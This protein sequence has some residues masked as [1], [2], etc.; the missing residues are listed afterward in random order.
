HRNLQDEVTKE[1]N[2]RTA[3]LH[4]EK[5]ALLLNSKNRPALSSLV[6]E[7]QN[8]GPSNDNDLGNSKKL[9][10]ISRE[11]LDTWK[12][13]LRDSTKRDVP[14]ELC[15]HSL[16]CDHGKL[17]YEP[18]V[19][20]LAEENSVFVL[21]TEEEWIQLKSVFVV[22]YEVS[23]FYCATILSF[24]NSPGN[25][26]HSLVYEY[27]LLYLFSFLLSS[28]SLSISHSL[29]PSFFHTFNSHHHSFC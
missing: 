10:M 8:L 21:V 4:R 26:L 14:R 7:V 6:E 23:T 28:F 22:D 16:L 12:R 15:N 24:I 1:K 27:F 5:F 3:A 20:C 25:C 9:Y 29:P 19:E 13:F 17:L 18:E 11:F 2:R